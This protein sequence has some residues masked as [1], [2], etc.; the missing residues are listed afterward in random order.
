MDLSYEKMEKLN[1]QAYELKE[2]YKTVAII[3][4]T[5]GVI[6]NGGLSYF[7]ENDWPGNPD[8]SVFIEAYKNIGII[9]GALTL[10]KAVSSF[11]FQEPHK[12][13]K[14]R[15]S[16]I[17]ENYDEDEFQVKGWDESLCGDEEV[18]SKLTNWI[19]QQHEFKK[20]T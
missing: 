18:W 9:Q 7:F 20:Y 1:C 16:Y 11:P 6:D 12:N 13:L 3:S 14:G 4:S 10:S 5:Q 15:N 2:P 17:E 19:K 8:Y